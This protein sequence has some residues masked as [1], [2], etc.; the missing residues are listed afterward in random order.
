[1]LTVRH[2]YISA[3]HNYFGHHGQPAGEAVVE[4]V[5]EAVLVAGMGIEGDRF[6]GHKENYKGQITFFAREVYERLCTE[7]KVTD[8][9]PS[10]FRR[11]VITEGMDLNSLIGREFTVQGIRFA[12]VCE[13]TPCYW[14]EQAFHPGA[15][16]SLQGHG[17][18]RARILTSG[19][20]RVA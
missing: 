1:M 4:S 20:L 7:F 10:V 12:G 11:N 13:C 5:A 8:R 6:Y 14:M 15:E 2:I 3:S 18:L 16:A 9:E 19:T 17:G